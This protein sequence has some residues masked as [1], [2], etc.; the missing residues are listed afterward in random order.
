LKALGSKFFVAGMF[1]LSTNSYAA[2]IFGTAKPPS[3]PDADTAAVEVGVKFKSSVDGKITA[4]RFYRGKVNSSGYVVNLWSSAG[5][6][7]ARK[8]AAAGSTGWRNVKL[9]TPINIK[10]G[11]VYIASYFTNKGRYSAVN[12]GLAN[13]V[14]KGSL[15][16]LD[17]ASSGGN[18]VYRYASSSG[19]PNQTYLA[20]NYFVDVEFTASTTS[21]LPPTVSLQANPSTIQS[22]DSSS[23]VLSSSNATSCTGSGFSTGGAVSGSFS[24]SPSATTS[25]SV[26]C[27]GAGGSASASAT[28]TV[29]ATPPPPPPPPSGVQLPGPSAELHANNPYYTC[30]NNLYVSTSGN[31]ANNGT[32]ASP[33]KTLSR[34]TALL[35]STAAARAGYC[36][37]VM[38]GTYNVPDTNLE[39]GGNVASKTGFVVY[40]SMSLNGAKLKATGYDI[41][42]LFAPYIIIDGF[43]LIG[44]RSN[45]AGINSCYNYGFHN[46]V[47]HIISMNNYVH[48]M[49]DGGIKHCWAEWFWVIH[50]RM[51]LN[52]NNTW[53]S[54]VTTYQ[55]S[56]VSSYQPTAYDNQ[57]TPYHNVYVYNRMNGNLTAPQNGPHT[58]GNGLIYDDTRHWQS[59]PNTEYAPRALIMGNLSWANG[60]SG[61][62]V[63]PSSAHADVFNNTAYKNML[64][65]VNNATWRGDFYAQDA[66]DVVF[67]N[68]IAYAIPGSGYLQYNSPFLV[69]NSESSV[70]LLRNISFGAN[71]TVLSPA[72]F[73]A[74]A[75]KANVNP[76]MVNPASGN[77]ALCTGVGVPAASCT[78]ASPAIGY[79]EVVPYWQQQTA[80]Q[81]D[82]GA[83]PAGIVACP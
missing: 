54:G 44:T 39:K 69:G 2:N 18:G 53:D 55:P 58:D 72:V 35:P 33:V 15:T 22:G 71:N 81:V 9:N 43:E 63:G 25:Y 80:G 48:D 41:L 13:A 76:L 46:G 30:V 28:V 20:S 40:R 6:N 11:Q 61:I 65:T 68:N 78:G 79:G 49:G 26:S 23:L 73:S 1:L 59:T 14:V 47:H 67:K 36:V 34:A 62:R 83:C 12:N 57:W 42:R 8:N 66:K 21:P 38:D 3:A 27:S 32:Q 45:G 37:N 31:D 77:F 56:E 70:L 7:L 4:I 50:N 5:T 52:A 60:G 19:F 10:A 29:S 82:L 24:V 16:A 17:S 51:D 75:N 64:D 74:T